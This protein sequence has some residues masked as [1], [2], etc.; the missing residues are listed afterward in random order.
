[1]LNLNDVKNE[2]IM[3]I[4]KIDMATDKK[5]KKLM[6]Y[7]E[8]RIMKAARS[9]KNNISIS[10]NTSDKRALIVLLKKLNV[11]GFRHSDMYYAD[12]Y[13]N[14]IFYGWDQIALF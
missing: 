12:G 6:K 5:A 1:M 8:K 13:I 10:F 3:A 11:L 14:V 4:E 9:C 2:Y 7:V